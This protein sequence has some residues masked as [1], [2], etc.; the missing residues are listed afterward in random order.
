MTEHI[1]LSGLKG[2]IVFL[3][4]T[5]ALLSFVAYRRYGTR[6][7]LYTFAGFLIL[8]LGSVTEGILFE[9][10]HT[11]LDLAHLIE[12]SI[13]LM[14]LLVLAYHLRPSRGGG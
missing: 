12:S 3:G 4:T 13:T 2:L 5:I 9:I 1:L 7:M 6:L 11:P 8:T 14:G 10:V